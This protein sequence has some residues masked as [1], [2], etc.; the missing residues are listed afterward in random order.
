VNFC[1]LGLMLTIGGI[2]AFTL[3]TAIVARKVTTR[4]P[5]DPADPPSN[6]GIA[7][8]E[9]HFASRDKTPLVGWWIPARVPGAFTIILCHGQNGSMD[10]D[11]R[12]M[13]PL[14]RAGFNVLMFDMRAHGRSGGDQITMGMYEKE[15]LLGALDHL[16][17]A[18]GVVRVGVLGFSM[19]AATAL[20]TAALTDR[21]VA[22]VADG[23][24]VHFKNTMARQIMRQG[25]PSYRVAWQ[26]AAWALVAAAVSTE[27]RIDQVDVMLWTPHVR[28]PVLFIHGSA[29]PLITTEEVRR[30]SELCAGPY[31]LW[32]VE[33]VGHR[34]TYDT[35]PNKYNA[36]VIDWFNK[37]CD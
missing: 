17:T 27:G 12:Q 32:I 16:D 22:V 11:T 29:D 14:H 7:Y 33:G 23:S 37:Y 15:D 3:L 24:F 20:I 6:Y 9:V 30:M 35:N 5:P 31:E 4:R 26:I 34:G 10:H 19:G 13:V 21:I 18:H 25:V 1:I 28:C 2:V 8:E 36:R